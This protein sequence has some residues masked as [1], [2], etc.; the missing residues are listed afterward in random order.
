[1][2]VYMYVLIYIYIYWFQIMDD[3]GSSCRNMTN[4]IF[5]KN[6]MDIGMEPPLQPRSTA[7]CP[8]R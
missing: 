2:Y 5:N 6:G 7:V 1:M 8:G 3:Y 4:P